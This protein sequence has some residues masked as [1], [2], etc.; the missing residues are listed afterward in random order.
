MK[1][2][3]TDEDVVNVVRLAQS[4]QETLATMPFK[5]SDVLPALLVIVGVETGNENHDDATIEKLI[6]HSITFLRLGFELGQK[7]AA[8]R[9]QSIQND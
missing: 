1:D 8:D 7:M 3:V 2:Q 6:K 5:R 4:L 9:K